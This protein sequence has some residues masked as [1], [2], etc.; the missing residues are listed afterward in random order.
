[1]RSKEFKG[2]IN[3]A[4]YAAAGQREE[5]EVEMKRIMKKER[6]VGWESPLI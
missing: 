4:G 6:M 1:M 5:R 2:N 3:A